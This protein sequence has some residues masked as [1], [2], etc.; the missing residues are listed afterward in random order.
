MTIM[1][2]G[3]SGILGV[4]DGEVDE[5]TIGV[6]VGVLPTLKAALAVANV[7]PLLVSTAPAEIV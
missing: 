1:A 2:D 4:G 5:V 3:N 7:A 6:A